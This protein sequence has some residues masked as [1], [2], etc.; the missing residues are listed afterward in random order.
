MVMNVI[1][2]VLAV[3][4]YSFVNIGIEEVFLIWY[5]SGNSKR[6]LINSTLSNDLLSECYYGFIKETLF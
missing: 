1:L 4:V 2:E 3:I 5:Y 6:K